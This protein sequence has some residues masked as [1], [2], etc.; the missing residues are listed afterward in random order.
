MRQ[1]FRIVVVSTLVLGTLDS[2]AFD[3]QLLGHESFLMQRRKAFTLQQR[4]HFS[5]ALFSSEREE[6]QTSQSIEDEGISE[7]DARILREM[8][9]ESK[10]DLQTEEDIKKLLERGVTKGIGS[11]DT[12]SNSQAYDDKAESSFQSE[13]FQK[14]ADTSLWRS[15]SAKTNDLLESAKIWVENKIEQDVKTLAALGIFAWDRIVKD[16]SRALPAAGSTA[17]KT[18]FLLTNSSSFVEKEKPMTPESLRNELNRPA[19]EI[20]SV[21]QA[22]W[23][24]L[25]G[26]EIDDG[27]RGLRTVAKAGTANMAERQRRAFE[28]TRKK[29]DQATV[30]KSVTSIPGSLADATYELQREL[31]AESNRAGYKTQPI[32]QAIEAGVVGTGKYLQAIQETARLAAAERKAKRLNPSSEESTATT[33]EVKDNSPPPFEL[34]DPPRAATEEPVQPDF[35]TQPYYSTQIIS[36]TRTKISTLGDIDKDEVLIDLQI[37]R[38][39]LL[40]RL[41]ACIQRPEETWLQPDMLTEEAKE[42][43]EESLR[44]IAELM[45]L[46]KD[47]LN[48]TST[49]FDEA[50]TVD[51]C[52]S[53]LRTDL[54]FIEELRGTVAGSISMNIANSL[55]DIIVGF[56]DIREGENEIPLLLRLDAFEVALT[57]YP[58]PPPPVPVERETEDTEVD[59]FQ[60]LD[61][62]SDYDE[63]LPSLVD[64]VTDDD[65]T[66]IEEGTAASAKTRDWETTT[67]NVENMLSETSNR[68]TSSLETPLDADVVEVIPE[69][70]F[71]A[72][73]ST[74]DSR[75]N[76]REPIIFADLDAAGGVTAE[77][78]SDDDFEVAVGKQKTVQSVSEEEEEEKPSLVLNLVLRSFDVIFFV[79][80]K[81]LFVVVPKSIQLATTAVARYEEANQGG[82]GKKGWDRIKNS[83]DPKGRY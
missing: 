83:A 73:E 3:P 23:N 20:K 16:V 33:E 1:W 18:I 79:L 11:G 58:P 54:S 4:Q 80:E 43:S 68:G 2:Y 82:K 22:I 19:D 17:K 47:E 75:E 41:S 37:E 45:I 40:N 56:Y 5:V 52:L 29:R 10:L 70:V 77:L 65:W 44:E 48:S 66:G 78:V 64:V 32:R 34:Y 59:P 31:K 28:Q 12:T 15:V 9:Q 30:A 57:E 53:Q 60:S 62:G 46:L 27:S 76:G 13:L 14:L 51:T 71:T 67:G 36:T 8:L 50:E 49:T 74:E 81:V 25:N 61:E 72:F 42:L 6:Q 69:A 35:Q 7:V 39:A 26:K 24:I 55:F 63:V 21:S 38:D